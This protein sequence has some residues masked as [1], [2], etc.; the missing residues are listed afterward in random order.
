M[1]ILTCTASEAHLLAISLACAL[2]IDAKYEFL[3]PL[4]ACQAD[5]FHARRAVSTFTAMSANM[6]ET[7]CQENQSIIT[8]S[9]VCSEIH[10]QNI[11]SITHLLKIY[12][13]FSFIN[14]PVM[15]VVI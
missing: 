11:Y 4:S 6:N 1:V 3:M 8:I 10:C 2:A 5:I 9:T 12:L 14:D 13:P 15:H 7:A